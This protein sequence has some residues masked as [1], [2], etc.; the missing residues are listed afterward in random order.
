MSGNTRPMFDNG[1]FFPGSGRQLL[2]DKDFTCTCH[3]LS[4]RNLAA[5]PAQ[6]EITPNLVYRSD[7]HTTRNS[8][9]FY[10]SIDEFWFC[11]EIQL[12]FFSG[13]IS[14]M[15]TVVHDQSIIVTILIGV[16]SF[17][18]HD[19]WQAGP[20]PQGLF[21]AYSRLGEL[22]S[23]LDDVPYTVFSRPKDARLIGECALLL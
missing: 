22:R 13:S 3:T 15:F 16:Y 7:W 11:Y 19:Y 17:Q 5:C 14:S 10:T 2:N 9:I 8:Q 6:Y 21:P 1:T 4:A 18:Y 12:W 20:I 23:F